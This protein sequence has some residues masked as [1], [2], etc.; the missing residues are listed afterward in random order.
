MA[1]RRPSTYSYGAAQGGPFGLSRVRAAGA[2][3]GEPGKR[4]YRVGR[5]LQGSADAPCRTGQLRIGARVFDAVAR[6]FGRIRGCLGRLATADREQAPRADL[7]A[8]RER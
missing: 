1:R 3:P 6:A 7:Q 8:R 5:R 2:A 4:E